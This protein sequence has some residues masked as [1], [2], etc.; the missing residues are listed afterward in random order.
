ML[1]Y[2][3][4]GD[5]FFVECLICQVAWSPNGK[6]PSEEAII[7]N[8]MW[9]CVSMNNNIIVYFSSMGVKSGEEPRTY[10][11]AGCETS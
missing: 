6:Y 3:I 2:N 4:E 8:V 7:K 10:M 5:L 11:G 1:Y 9:L